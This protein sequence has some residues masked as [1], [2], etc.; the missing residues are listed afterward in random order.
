MNALDDLML[1]QSPL[2][3]LFTHGADSLQARMNI[4][5]TFSDNRARHTAMAE[6]IAT[7]E[8]ICATEQA[9]IDRSFSES[10]RLEQV[11]KFVVASLNT[12]KSRHEA[13]TNAVEQMHNKLVFIVPG[14]PV[15]AQ[16]IYKAQAAALALKIQDDDGEFEA[17]FSGSMTLLSSHLQQGSQHRLQHAS[18]YHSLCSYVEALKNIKAKFMDQHCP[19]QKPVPT[20]SFYPEQWKTADAT[21]QLI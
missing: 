3:T 18:F 12:I 9:F 7:G 10:Q 8:L 20:F 6:V 4:V 16:A 2:I 19:K 21:I 1:S 15:Q 17:T 13:F 5:I 14:V 11:Y